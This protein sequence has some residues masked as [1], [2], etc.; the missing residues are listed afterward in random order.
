LQNIEASE[1]LLSAFEIGDLSPEALLFQTQ[2]AGMFGGLGLWPGVMLGL[3]GVAWVAD[4]VVAAE[5][6][7]LTQPSV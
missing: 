3:F 6:G 1:G 5:M 7:V 4:G 2:G